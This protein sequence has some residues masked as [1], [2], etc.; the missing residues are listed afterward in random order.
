MP[1]INSDNH[2]FC[3]LI[4]ESIHIHV[5]TTYTRKTIELSPR[6]LENT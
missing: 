2:N 3:K 4:M 1:C 6:L 5:H